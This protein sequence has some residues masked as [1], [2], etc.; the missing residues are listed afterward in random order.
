MTEDFTRGSHPQC[1]EA[2]RPP[3]FSTDSPQLLQACMISQGQFICNP[4]QA[5][6]SPDGR[7]WDEDP[8]KGDE[9]FQIITIVDS[10]DTIKTQSSYTKPL[11]GLQ[12][13]VRQLGSGQVKRV[14]CVPDCYVTQD[15]RSTNNSI[16]GNVYT[17]SEVFVQAYCVQTSEK[18]FFIFIKKKKESWEGC[19]GP[20]SLVDTV[21][22]LFL[23]HYRSLYRGQS[24]FYL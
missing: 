19:Q 9:S 8:P 5:R 17:E 23:R 1:V 3:Q 11:C 13:T 7:R 24:P 20:K 15:E 10:F 18:V 2:K 16:S 4:D 14:P 6:N 12:S 21:K 22:D